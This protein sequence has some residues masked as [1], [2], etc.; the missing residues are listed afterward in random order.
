MVI[1]KEALYVAG[2]PQ[3]KQK[4]IMKSIEKKRPVKDVYLIT[5]PSNEANCLEYVNANQILQPYY[6]KRDVVVYGLAGSETAAQELAATMVCGAY[7]ATGT[8]SVIP[9][10]EARNRGE[11][12]GSS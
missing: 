6:R 7:A 10:L 12:G 4:R 5:A 3:K 2:V 8:F 11:A 9:Y 1:W